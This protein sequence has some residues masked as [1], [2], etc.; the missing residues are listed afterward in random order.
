MATFGRLTRPP[1]SA[2]GLVGRIV[3]GLVATGAAVICAWL[4]VALLGSLLG[5][6]SRDPHGYTL[7]FGSLLL[8]P[9][10][11]VGALALPFAP[12]PGGRGR[13]IAG[14]VAIVWVVGALVLAGVSLSG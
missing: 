14:C 13:R 1:R 11:I 8:V 9:T 7:V 5:P 10:S 3:A 12:P 4:T 6:T 2:W